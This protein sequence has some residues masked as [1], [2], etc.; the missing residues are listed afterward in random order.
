MNTANES[1]QPNPT[2]PRTNALFIALKKI[3][4]V[5]LALMG[6]GFIL[7]LDSWYMNHSDMPKLSRD[8]SYGLL[9][10]IGFLTSWHGSKKAYFG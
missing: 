4:A 2:H 5:T 10:L 9:T 3:A 7:W 8:M 1:L 6:I